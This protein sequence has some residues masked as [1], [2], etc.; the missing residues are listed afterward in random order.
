MRIAV[1]TGGGSGIGA[2]AAVA[3]AE[4]GWSLRPYQKEAVTG[5][6]HGGSGVVVLP[7]G[8]G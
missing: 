4:D 6:W 1:V 5:F 8:A 3:L 7:C 2:A